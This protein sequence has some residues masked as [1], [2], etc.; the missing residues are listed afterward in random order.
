[1]VYY[2]NLYSQFFTLFGLIG[3]IVV[4]TMSSAK[5]PDISED[6]S[7]L[8]ANKAN[9]VGAWMAGINIGLG[10]LLFLIALGQ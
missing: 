6:E 9:T 5:A 3:L 4:S 2:I 7:L 8:R 10:V 1:M